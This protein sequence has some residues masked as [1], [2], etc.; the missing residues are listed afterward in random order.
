MM[1]L[2]W[3]NMVDR[4]DAMALRE[5]ILI[6]IA[7]LGVIALIWD[8]LLMQPIERARKVAAPQV[9][10]LRMEID[11]LNNSV[12]EAASAARSD[13][14]AALR[15][16]L[17]KARDSV[18]SLETALKGLTG[19]LIA[20]EEMVEVL[21]NVLARTSPL[22]LIR[23]ETLTPEPLVAMV[24]GEVLPSQIYR[25]RVKLELEGSYLQILDF[26]AEIEK[27]PWQFYW[28]ELQLTAEEHPRSRVSITL[29]TLGREEAWI[30]V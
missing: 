21:K 11:R 24:P 23:L 17:S 29:G 19:G 20:P 9:D 5:R 30:G 14:N 3:Q 27:L 22:Q 7:L 6:M 13:P 8:A 15:A 18:E 2:W 16:E 25:H 12:A 10:N 1:R 28:D 26:V 4:V